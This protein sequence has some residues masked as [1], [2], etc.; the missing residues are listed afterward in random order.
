MIGGGRDKGESSASGAQSWRELAGPKRG[1]LKSPQARKRRVQ[2][3]VK[4]LCF[5]V[6][7]LSVMGV[8]VWA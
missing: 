5:M 6:A 4:G 7:V 3:V 8:G 1:K 2:R